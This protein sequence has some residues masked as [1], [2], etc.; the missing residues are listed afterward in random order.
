MSK[1]KNGRKSG[2][3]NNITINVV[4][5]KAAARRKKLRKKLKQTAQMSK[6]PRKDQTGLPDDVSLQDLTQHCHYCIATFTNGAYVTHDP[7]V[8]F[9][10][11]QQG[12]E[13]NPRYN[14]FVYFSP[15]AWKVF[16]LKAGMQ[17][18]LFT[19]REV[20]PRY[21]FIQNVTG[22]FEA[23]AHLHRYGMFTLCTTHVCGGEAP[24]KTHVCRPDTVTPNGFIRNSKNGKLPMS[25]FY[26]YPHL[27]GKWSRLYQI[28]DRER[29]DL[30][31]VRLNEAREIPDEI[32]LR[33]VRPNAGLVVSP[34]R[35]YSTVGRCQAAS[36]DLN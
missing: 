14:D 10:R 28:S 15:Q 7:V 23:P 9:V 27:I 29:T 22:E 34:T 11:K 17:L 16:G 1:R 12:T 3:V 5:S 30:L 32:P 20:D 26:K 18:A 35:P 33:A 36:P 19:D 24:N 6:A 8:R 13:T 2:V 21:L 25:L 4:G 31:M